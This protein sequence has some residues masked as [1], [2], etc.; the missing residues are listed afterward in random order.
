MKKIKF[1]PLLAVGL[2]ALVGCG[3]S[4]GQ[5]ISRNKA[6]T[7]YSEDVVDQY[8]LHIEDRWN[9][10]D[11]VGSVDPEGPDA[12]KLPQVWNKKL[13]NGTTIE[14]VTAAVTTTDVYYNLQVFHQNQPISTTDGFMNHLDESI[15]HLAEEFQENST[16]TLDGHKLKVH[17]TGSMD[18]TISEKEY[19]LAMYFEVNF[20]KLGLLTNAKFE[21]M[22]ST[23]FNAD[24]NTSETILKFAGELKCSY[25]AA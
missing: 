4:G 18:T 17:F 3:S 9:S 11:S 15:G 24:K 1:L 12:W 16:Y 19:A 8:V 14:D 20:N 10:F 6:R 21:L 5:E 22:A 25:T 7:L 2:L 13:K 23:D